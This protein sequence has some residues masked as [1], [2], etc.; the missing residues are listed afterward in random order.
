MVQAHLREHVINGAVVVLK[1]AREYLGNH[2]GRWVATV[3]AAAKIEPE[4]VKAT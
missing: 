3:Q 4:Q 1:V 2:A